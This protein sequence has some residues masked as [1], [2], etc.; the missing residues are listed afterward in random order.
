MSKPFFSQNTTRLGLAALL[1]AA[2]GY[3]HGD[4]T[5][6][7]AI[8]AAVTGLLGLAAADHESR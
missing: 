1:A 6:T 2:A 3:F 7:Q 4:L 5:I 8:M